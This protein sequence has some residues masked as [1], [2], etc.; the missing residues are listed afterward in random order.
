MTPLAVFGI[1]RFRKNESCERL[2]RSQIATGIAVKIAIQARRI[3]SLRRNAHYNENTIEGAKAAQPMANRLKPFENRAPCT[4]V[5]VENTTT[6]LKIECRSGEK[7]REWQKVETIGPLTAGWTRN[8][9]NMLQ[10]IVCNLNMVDTKRTGGPAN[11]RL[12][13]T[14][15]G[16]MNTAK[17]NGPSKQIS[18]PSQ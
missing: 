12:R 15:T 2:S 13:S 5:A 18:V 6:A 10:S 14:A 1:M 16:N 3:Q 17:L 8:I 9:D 4:A 7:V 11:D